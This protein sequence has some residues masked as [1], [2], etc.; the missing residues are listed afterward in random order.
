MVLFARKRLIE[1]LAY[2][3]NME[4]LRSIRPKVAADLLR[5]NSQL[6]DFT[7]LSFLL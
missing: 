3:N 1:R 4:Y 2:L 5:Y 6:G 7:L